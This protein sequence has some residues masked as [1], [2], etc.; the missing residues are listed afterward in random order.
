ARF[1]WRAA[2][3]LGAA[4]ALP[5]FALF[6]VGVRPTAPR[7][8]D[9][10]VGERLTVGPILELL[11]RPEI[12][13]TVVLA[14]LGAFT[15]QAVA[16]FLPAY[17]EAGRGF[18]GTTAGLLFSAYFVVHGATQPVLGQLSDRYSRDAVVAGAMGVGV[19]GFAVLVLGEG[20][21]TAVAGVLAV[22]VA[23]SWGAPLQSRF[24]DVLSDTER[25]AGFGLVRTVYMTVGAAGSLVVGAAADLFGWAAAFGLLSAVLAVAVAVIAANHLLGLGY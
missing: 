1:G 10:P 17:L 13:Y 21:P 11:S 12:G 14:V 7:R 9:Q 24:I 22:G 16:S 5:A 19:V 3:A 20:M 25:G 6:A 8:P 23:M 18:T 4:V 2:L 15:W